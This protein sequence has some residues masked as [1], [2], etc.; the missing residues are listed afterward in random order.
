MPQT[1]KSIRILF[2]ISKLNYK[3]FSKSTV[4]MYNIQT[5]PCFMLQ[6]PIILGHHTLNTHP[7]A[8]KS[9]SNWRNVIQSLKRKEMKRKTEEK[10]RGL[11]TS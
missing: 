5:R 8:T 9:Y 10:R 4:K 3:P 7:L 11:F 1:L 6:F 2:N